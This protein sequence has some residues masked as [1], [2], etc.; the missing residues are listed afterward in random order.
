M[1]YAF[2]INKYK[3]EYWINYPII[4][5]EFRQDLVSQGMLAYNG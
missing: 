1:N 2:N 4:T 3:N 5:W